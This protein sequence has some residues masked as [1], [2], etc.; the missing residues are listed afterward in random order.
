MSNLQEIKSTLRRLVMA[1]NFKAPDIG[2]PVVSQ[3]DFNTNNAWGFGGGYGTQFKYENGFVCRKGNACYRHTGESAFTKWSYEAN[4]VKGNAKLA[5]APVVHIYLVLDSND[6]Y[7]PLAVGS[8]TEI[9][10]EKLKKMAY[11]YIDNPIV[12]KVQ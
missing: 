12:K 3:E 2:S 1:K 7:L 8:A 4:G 5:S 6:H 10:E 9:D 11:E